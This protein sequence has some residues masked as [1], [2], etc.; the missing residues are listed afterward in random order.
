MYL[1][2]VSSLTVSCCVFGSFVESG[3]ELDMFS[4]LSPFS[5]LISVFLVV[6]YSSCF[7]CF[8][9][10][11]FPFS[12]WRSCINSFFAF[13]CVSFMFP[14]CFNGCLWLLCYF[15]F[16]GFLCCLPDLFPS[17]FFGIFWLS[18]HF[19]FVPCFLGGFFCCFLPCSFP[20]SPFS[21]MGLFGRFRP[22]PPMC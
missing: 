17:I 8:F 1:V 11:L 12:V 5:I 9:L 3:F 18:L 10:P 13:L 20:C 22:D 6:A 21:R 16:C 7:C 14:T 2:F 19:R 15:C 4:D